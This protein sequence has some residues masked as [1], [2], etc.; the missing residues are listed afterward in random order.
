MRRLLLLIAILTVGAAAQSAP[1]VP[2]VDGGVGACWV[3]FTVTQNGKPV[4]DAQIHAL[5]R[6]GVFHKID[7][8]VG[9]NADGKARVTG[10]PQNVKKPPLVFDIRKGRSVTTVS[11]D[12]AANC[13]AS[14]DVAL[15][16]S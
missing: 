6:Y 8:Q 1:E 4:Y 11:H 16:S 10:L 7:L 13:H 9:T 15:P 5:V 12:P 2:K 3:D 14:Y